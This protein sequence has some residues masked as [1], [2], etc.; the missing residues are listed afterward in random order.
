MKYTFSDRMKDLSANAIREIF[1]LISQPDIISFAGG[2]PSTQALPLEQ[3]KEIADAVLS[4][5]KA[6]RIL[7][8]GATEGYK[9]FLEAGLKY[10][11]RAGIYNQNLENILAISGGQQ[12]IDLMCKALLNKGDKVLVEEPTYLAVLHI[13]K[14]YEACPIGVKSEDDGIDLEDLEKKIMEHKPKMLYLVPTFSN[15]TGKTI[16]VEKRKKIAEIC[17]KHRLVLLEDDPYCE[18]RYEGER[19]P[20]IKSFD[21]DGWVVYTISFSKTISPGLRT[22]LAVGDKE[23]IRKMTLGKQA[24]DVHTSLLSQAIVNEYLRRGYM[25]PQLEKSTAI[26]KEKKDCMLEKM[27]EYFP[28]CVKYTRPE[29]GLFIWV[30]LPKYMD[31]RKLFLQAVEKKV[32]FVD[33]S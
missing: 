33:G 2:L 9:P 7:Q 14:T 23:I 25:D 20:S 17:Q 27:D 21:K 5:D 22:A 8:Y 1:K 30:V 18:L 29:G 10:I 12:A 15:P 4:S 24:T 6:V 13:L 19:V 26:Y 16:T 11:E 31:A 28:P 3:V 32:A